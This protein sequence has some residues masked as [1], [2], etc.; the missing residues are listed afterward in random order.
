MDAERPITAADP[1][2]ERFSSRQVSLGRRNE[3]KAGQKVE[4]RK[5]IVVTEH[6]LSGTNRLSPPAALS[7]GG[8]ISLWGNRAF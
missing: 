4:K 8:F 3:G 2:T 6:R 1:D 5:R 7:S